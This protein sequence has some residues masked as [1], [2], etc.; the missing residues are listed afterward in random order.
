M[1]G[2]TL[3]D[4]TALFIIALSGFLAFL[5]GFVREFLALLGWASS[6]ILAFMFA[7]SIV[8]IVQEIPYL[9][10]IIQG[11]EAATVASF[12]IMLV[13]SLILV[14][15]FITFFSNIIKRTILN[16][17]DK[18]LG[19][20]FGVI[21]GSILV[22]VSLVFYNQV[23][24]GNSINSIEKSFTNKIISQISKNINTIS[25][26]EVSNWVVSSYEGLLKKCDDPNT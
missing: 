4:G 17:V 19:L 11:C 16:T 18:P 13:I 7:S 8:P 12:A 25:P 24:G 6:I 22:T 21:R 14:S 23:A 20:L 10:K 3:I 1:D 9:N 2:F 5:R 15:I 26:D